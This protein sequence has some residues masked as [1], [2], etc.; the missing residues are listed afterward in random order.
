[1]HAVIR[2]EQVP[3]RPR[4]TRF[5]AA[6]FGACALLALGL[7]G[8]APESVTDAAPGD[9]PETSDGA[10][11]PATYE[12]GTATFAVGDVTFTAD[13]ELCSLYDGNDALFGG[14]VHDDGGEVIG[15]LDGDFTNS[16]GELNGE[17]RIDLGATRKLQSTDMFVAMGAPMGPID[18]TEFTSDNLALTATAWDDEGADRGTATL[19]VRCA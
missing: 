3:R 18:V 14:P 4:P 17:A 7:S 12:I 9:H 13:L 5:V 15:Y 16:S 1:M 10:N 6:V 8:C 11:T 19:S 2:F